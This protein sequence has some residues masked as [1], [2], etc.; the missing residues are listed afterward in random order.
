ML[1][2]WQGILEDAGLGGDHKQLYY[3]Q[4]TTFHG[5]KAASTLPGSNRENQPFGD[6]DGNAGLQRT[7]VDFY[8]HWLPFL[9]EHRRL[10]RLQPAYF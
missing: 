4:S 10:D 2:A 5:K 3:F 1:S 8:F 6:G 9:C 7:F